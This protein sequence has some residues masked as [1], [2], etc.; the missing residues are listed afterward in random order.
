[1]YWTCPDV[2]VCATFCKTDGESELHTDVHS[3]YHNDC[4]A[5]SCD[6]WMARIACAGCVNACWDDCAADGGFALAGD[7]VFAAAGDAVVFALSVFGI[8]LA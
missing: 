5:G 2:L 4:G 1:M 7:G 3:G 8:G 6:L